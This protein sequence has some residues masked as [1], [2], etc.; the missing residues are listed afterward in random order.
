MGVVALGG[1]Q[2]FSRWAVTARS[3]RWRLRRKTVSLCVAWLW[4]IPGVTGLALVGAAVLLAPADRSE[5]APR[6]AAW[7]SPR[8]RRLAL[9]ALAA[10]LAL[11]AASVG[12]QYAA[13][14]YLDRGRSQL[15]SEPTTALRDAE[16]ALDLNPASLPA[17]YLAA[18]AHARRDEY[19]P[20]RRVLSAAA[21]KEPSDYVPWVLL[22]DLAVRR[23]ELGQARR[24]YARA[25]ALSPFDTHFSVPASTPPQEGR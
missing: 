6:I 3:P 9:G 10:A 2:S 1:T 14:W 15:S 21:R 23:G 11:V 4:S 19:A 12:R 13:D 20:A 18:A 8:R 17:H 24:D 7:T 5:R 16:R 22:G 25:H